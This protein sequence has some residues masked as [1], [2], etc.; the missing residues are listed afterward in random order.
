MPKKEKKLRLMKK[1][2]LSSKKQKKKG[3][4]EPESALYS[5]PHGWNDEEVHL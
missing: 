1:G 3:M 4:L 2:M 5:K